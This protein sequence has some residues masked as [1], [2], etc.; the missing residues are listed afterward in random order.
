MVVF[1]SQLGWICAVW[2]DHRLCGLTFGHPSSQAAANALLALEAVHADPELHHQQLAERLQ[3]FAAGNRSDDFHDVTLD[4]SHLTPFQRK[5]IR[6]CRRIPAG[7]TLSYGQLAARAGRPRAA[8]AVGRVMATNRF[9][10]IVPCHRVIAANGK[11]GGYSA[12][13]GLAMKRRLLAD[14]GRSTEGLRRV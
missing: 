3:D 14:E 8:R 9:P 7:E 2:R 5:V 6:H 10:L 13:Q 1:P 4:E 12:P 11:L